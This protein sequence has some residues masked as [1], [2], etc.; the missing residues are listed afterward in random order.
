VP[1]NMGASDLVRARDGRRRLLRVCLG[2]ERRLRGFRSRRR[3]AIVFFLFLAWLIGLAVISLIA[4]LIDVYQHMRR[5]P[6]QT[7]RGC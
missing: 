3:G 4:W 1:K 2:R 6:Q 7:E 5:R